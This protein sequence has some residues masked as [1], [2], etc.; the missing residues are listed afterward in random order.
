MRRPRY[1]QWPQW[2]QWPL[3]SLKKPINIATYHLK[4]LMSTL[5]DIFISRKWY[6]TSIPQ[7]M[8]PTFKQ[9]WGTQTLMGGWLVLFRSV[10]LQGYTDL[11]L[12]DWKLQSGYYCRK[13]E[14]YVLDVTMKVLSPMWL[15]LCYRTHLCMI[16]TEFIIPSI[17]TS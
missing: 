17:N 15:R 5:I 7:W 3:W 14:R 16:E 6:S 10:Y 9:R 11:D 12:I 1:N 4:G 8:L 2:T 13:N